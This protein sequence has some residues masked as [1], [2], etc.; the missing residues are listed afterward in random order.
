MSGNWIDGGNGSYRGK[1]CV[2]ARACR[3]QRLSLA[4]R[5]FRGMCCVARITSIQWRMQWQGAVHVF[6]RTSLGT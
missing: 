3:G 1:Y 2:P 5:P 4:G 6:P